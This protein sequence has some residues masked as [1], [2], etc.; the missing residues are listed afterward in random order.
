MQR[1]LKNDNRILE[2]NNRKIDVYREINEKCK[3]IRSRYLRTVDPDKNK[4]NR[5]QYIAIRSN[6]V[7]HKSRLI[8][9]NIQMK[10]Q[11]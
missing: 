5:L 2:I 1:D 4:I 10:H 11:L 3:D 6:Q 8:I 7:I 9:Q